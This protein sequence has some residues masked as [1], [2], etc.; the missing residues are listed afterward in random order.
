MDH[1]AAA[2]RLSTIEPAV[3]IGYLYSFGPTRFHLIDGPSPL[4]QELRQKRETP[5]ARS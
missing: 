4:G 1:D 3:A 5:H 2:P